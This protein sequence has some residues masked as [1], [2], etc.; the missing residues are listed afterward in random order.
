MHLVYEGG[1]RLSPGHLPETWGRGGHDSASSRCRKSF[2]PGQGGERRVNVP[3]AGELFMAPI[4]RK[5]VLNR[6][7]RSSRTPTRSSPAAAAIHWKARGEFNRE[8]VG[9][10]NIRKAATC[11][12]DALKQRRAFA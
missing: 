8:V 12:S 3:F 5:L 11:S 7:K 6:S 1:A 2:A 9:W 4:F 10:R